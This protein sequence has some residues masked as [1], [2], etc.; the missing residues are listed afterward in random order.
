MDGTSRNQVTK[1]VKP[2]QFT[3]LS[4]ILIRAGHFGPGRARRDLRRPAG[5]AATFLPGRHPAAAQQHHRYS[6]PGPPER[7]V[8]G[9]T[10]KHWHTGAD[11]IYLHLIGPANAEGALLLG[12]RMWRRVEGCEGE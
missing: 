10:F 2:G 11:V 5:A 7:R 3:K 9:R 4:R 12:R 6:L 8:L 1:A